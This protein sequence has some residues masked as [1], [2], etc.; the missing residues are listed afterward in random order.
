[1]YHDHHF[2]PLGYTQLVNGLE[3]FDARDIDSLLGMVSE[4]GESRDGP[5]VGQRVNDETLA[6][7]RLPTRTDI[8]DV[9]SDRP[10]FLYRYCG[11]V[12]MANSVALE[13]SRVDETTPDPEGGSIDRDHSGRPTGVLREDAIG[14]V[15][16]VL[17][18]RV[19][20]PT[21][22]E[23][24]SALAGLI[25]LG[26]GSVT[27]IVAASDPMWCGVGDEL[28]TI[29]RL[30]PE[31]PIDML[32]YV[33]A[34]DP[35]ALTLA[36]TRIETAGGR[37]Q[38]GGWKD[39]SDGSFG[40]RTAAM[41][42]PYTDDPSELGMVRLRHEHAIT[43]GE[44]SLGLGG[45][46][47]LHAIGDRANDMVLDIHEDLIGRGADPSKLRIEHA[48]ILTEAAVDRMARLGVTASVQPAFLASEEDWLLRRLGDERMNRVYPFRSLAEA[49]VTLLGGSDAPVENPDPEIGISSAVHRH[50][51]NPTESVSRSVA[52]SW[53][54]PP[55][56]L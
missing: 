47:A 33:T 25:D 38:F 15:A 29:C 45:G 26:L 5:I 34:D 50:G 14:L 54:R 44:T 6:D 3:L 11:H 21:D 30:A 4:F 22:E 42:Q 28:E 2:H 27:G 9:V 18:P 12:A 20:Q 55:V 52:Q 24:L 48:S 37:I 1:M 51:I 35:A 36:A 31:L 39:W 19:E 40:G 8:D 41:Y 32:L 7:G 56:F 17:A 16:D 43:M 13:L 53:F 46:V 10:V 49:G 23:V